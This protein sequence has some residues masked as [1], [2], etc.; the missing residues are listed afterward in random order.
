MKL[1]GIKKLQNISVC[2]WRRR[3]KGDDE[4]EKQEKKLERMGGYLV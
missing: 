1:T 3:R 4:Q 2:V